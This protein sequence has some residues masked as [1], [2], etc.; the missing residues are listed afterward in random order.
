MSDLTVG[1]QIADFIGLDL[2]RKKCP[3]FNSWVA[4]LES[5]GEGPTS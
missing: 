3:H 4:K 2:T 5:L 1:P